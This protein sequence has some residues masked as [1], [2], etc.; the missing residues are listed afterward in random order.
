[1]HDRRAI[2][3]IGLHS[4]PKIEIRFFCFLLDTHYSGP[5][6]CQSWLS[7]ATTPYHFQAIVENRSTYQG[8]N[9]PRQSWLQP[10]PWI[11]L[12]T[13]PSGSGVRVP[14]PPGTFPLPDVFI[15]PFLHG[16]VTLR[17][18]SVPREREGSMAPQEGSF[19][20]FRV[21]GI[22]VFL[23]WTWLIVAY[24]EIKNR[25]HSYSMPV[26]NVVEYLALF[27]IVLLHEFGHALACRQVGGRADRIILWPLGG[28]AYVLPPPRP[29]ALLWSIAAGPLVNLVLAPLTIALCIL[30]GL[31]GGPEQFPDFNH[32]LIAIAIINTCLLVFNLLPIYPLDGGQILQAVLWFIVGR[33]P[34][35][36]AA[37]AIGL[38]GGLGLILLA[39]WLGDW[40][41]VVI[42]VFIALQ[43]GNGFNQARLLR[44]Q[45]AAPRHAAVSCP[46]CGAAPPQGDHWV[47]DRCGTRFDTIVQQA[48]CPQCGIQFDKAAC[49]ECKQQHPLAD[50]Y[51]QAAAAPD[52]SDP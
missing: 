47:C 16:L 29:G 4:L 18:N 14:S 6:S 30:S 42:A 37:S 26:W 1:L 12:S 40:W 2:L 39:V 21:A 50:W 45:L 20:L 19:Q 35:L 22:S 10:I 33:V 25:A 49:P 15:N 11:V 41:L 48:V 13:E 38:V 52:S 51:P 7:M 31:A 9:H 34:S 3:Q 23:H 24:F 46:S 44:E 36:M 43:A 17:D 28:I 8:A 5:I 32:F 27:G